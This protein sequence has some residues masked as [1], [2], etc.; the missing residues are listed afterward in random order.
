VVFPVCSP[1]GGAHT[2]TRTARRLL[3]VAATL[4]CCAAALP[5]AAAGATLYH[6]PYRPQF[7][8]TPA[9]NWMN[10]PNGLIYYKGQYHLFFQ[11]NP[12][13]T[14]W[15]NISWGHAVSTD[16][17]HWKE[18]PLA[19]PADSNE[20]VFSG[21][22]VFDRRNSS[23]LGT[24]AN[25]PLVAIYTSTQK[26][27]GIQAQALAY[28]TDGGQTWT[29]YA[30]NPVLN[31]NSQNFRDPKVFWYAPSHRWMMVVARSD[32]HQVQFYSSPD[33]KHW[34]HL[35]DFG[36]AGATIGVWECPDLFPLTRKDG[37]T[38]WVLVVNVNP[39]SIAGGSGTQ[40]FVGSFN[41][42]RFVSD[43]PTSY[44]PPAGVVFD[45]FEASTYGSWTT[46]GT[47][48]G[49][50]PAQGTL[51]GQQTVTGYMGNGL[52]N[53]FLNGDASTGTLTSPTFTISKPYINFLLGGG[54]HPHVPGG[55]PYGTVPQGTV[56]DD[57]EGS[58]WGTGWTATGDF[59]NAG[60]TTE[61]L[62]GQIGA[63][64]LDTCVVSCDPAQG[65]IT[66]P[67]FT[68]NSDY[69]DFLIAG[70]DHPMSGANPT[71]VNLLVG[72]KVVATATGNNSGAMDWVSWNVAP[73]KGQQATIQVIDQNDGSSGWGHLI[74][75]EIV[76]S[77]SAAQPYDTET[78][79]NLLVG[80]QVVRTAT[81]QNSETLDW[82]SWD[83][84]DL[85]GQQAQ[86]Q[87]VDNNSGGW[88]HVN[89]DQ[90]MFADAPA[91]SQVQR[92]NWVDYGAD[93][94]ASNT[95]ND[96]PD[97]RRIEIAWMNNWN[98]GGNIPTSPWR[99]ADTFPRDLSLQ[100][101]NGK[102]QLVQQPVE[103]LKLLRGSAFQAH[104][105]KVANT[106]R[107]VGVQGQTLEIE[108]N[109]NAGTAT[110]FGLNVRVGSGQQTQI[111][112]DTTTHDVYIDRRNSGNVSFDPTFAG[113]Q[114]A[115][116]PLNH[117][118][119]TLHILV[120]ASSVEVFADQGQ[121]VLTDQ[122]FPDPASTGVTAFAQGGSASLAQFKAWH[123]HS[124]WP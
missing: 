116:L 100:S 38:K 70:G 33:L 64:V 41:G 39:G 51:P 93:F 13:G 55:V 115:P 75:D 7:H 101:I 42:T 58:T 36:P 103:E 82:T 31:L 1:R 59:T 84:H 86:I 27:T 35:S 112:Y 114:S 120:D 104:P 5:A 121:V 69:I 77:P 68:I 9:Q 24:A 37:T 108:A 105:M 110:R 98:Y 34:T 107:T 14:T 65:T 113:A 26:A 62:P 19:I 15:G 53:S 90:V 22:V 45:D 54:D 109:L 87:V 94:Y 43:G 71:A 122:I 25:P 44:T 95:Y 99:S 118:R 8:F 117:G 123:L 17:V 56:F 119:L 85:V 11:Y 52:V 28:S 46:T 47:A 18:L 106:T 67:T 72:G 49:S 78:G 21:S 50:G 76:F 73:Y 81:G 48:F 32:L 4:L 74:V 29:K 96:A 6:E 10:D 102:P 92:A 91:L 89:A 12:S 61:S 124:I 57:F 80:G 2:P 60:P 111:G 97:G 20:Y 16:L 40:Y 23:G 66:S 30:G 83:V 63:R 79:V 3:G 88:G